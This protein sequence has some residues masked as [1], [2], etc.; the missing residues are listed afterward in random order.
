M[1]DKK[2]FISFDQEDYKAL[3]KLYDTSKDSILIFK[4]KQIL[5]TYAKYVLEYLA[6]KFQ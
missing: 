2:E 3:K 1:S 6:T 4:G 5:R